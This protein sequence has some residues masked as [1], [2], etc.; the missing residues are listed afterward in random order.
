MADSTAGA[1]H[2]L[3]DEYVSLPLGLAALYW[4]RLFKPLLQA[5]LPQSPTNRGMKG[6]GFVGAHL[7]VGGVEVEG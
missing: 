2:H 4:I 7:A 1:A 3:E 6:L 5:D